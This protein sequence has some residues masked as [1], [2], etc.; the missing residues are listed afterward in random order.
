[1]AKNVK[2][3]VL[4]AVTLGAIAG[5]GAALISTVNLITKDQIALN[6]KNKTLNGLTTI[7]GNEATFSDEITIEGNYKYL[8]SYF[9]ASQNNQNIG[10]AYLTSGT[11]MYG[12]I[13]T[14]IGINGN[15]EVFY[16]YLVTNEQSISKFE[17]GYVDPFNKGDIELD[18]TKCGATYGAELVKE[19]AK[20]A[21]NY[22]LGKEA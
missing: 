12:K 14:L 18:D 8:I 9:D 7:F 4:T 10:R 6:E 1:M 21:V 3:Y 22:S 5:I 20:E 16:I 11:N 19:M 17:T 2:K 15:N 13:K